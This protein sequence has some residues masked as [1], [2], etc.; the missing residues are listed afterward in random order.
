MYASY[1][2]GRNWLLNM[3]VVLLG[4][5]STIGHHDV[6]SEVSTEVTSA[7]SGENSYLSLADN[8]EE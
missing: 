5:R 3:H 1:E 7:E 2:V 6:R 8:I 4:L